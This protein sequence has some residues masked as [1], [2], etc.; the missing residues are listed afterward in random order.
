MAMFPGYSSV[1]LPELKNDVTDLAFHDSPP[2]HQ[3]EPQ[4]YAVCGIAA[5]VNAAMVSRPEV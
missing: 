1:G 5:I 3:L 2:K 4:Q